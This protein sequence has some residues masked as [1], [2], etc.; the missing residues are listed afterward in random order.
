MAQ[1]TTNH[2]SHY[3]IDTFIVV[4]MQRVI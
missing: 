1:S 3:T 2:L 4:F